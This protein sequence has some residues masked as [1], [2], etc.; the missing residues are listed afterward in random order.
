MKHLLTLAAVLTA[1]LS[2]ADDGISVKADNVKIIKVD[3][4]VTIT[5]DR[6]V[7]GLPFDLEGPKGGAFYVWTAPQGAAFVDN[8]DSIHVTSCPGG[9]QVFGVKVVFAD[10]TINPE[11]Q[12][13]KV[14]TTTKLYSHK[15]HVDGPVPPPTPPTPPEPKPPVPPPPSPSPILSEDG[16]RVLILYERTGGEMLL[17]RTQKDELASKDFE[18]YLNA[19]CVKENGQAAWRR[20]DKDVKGLENAPAWWRTAM[21]LPRTDDRWLIVA[22]KDRG[23]S[24]PLP[25]GGKIL[26]RIKEILGD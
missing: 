20:W 10:G 14:T 25:A 21:A 17:S 5:E 4:V 7:V 24:E 1:G 19:K 9:C 15:L 16:P 2:A 26:D 11:T 3:R 6:E 22:N 8:G 13:V 18:D 23:I 12:K